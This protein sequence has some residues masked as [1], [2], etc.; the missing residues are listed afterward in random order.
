MSLFVKPHHLK[1]I[2]SGCTIV[3]L[4]LI[5]YTDDTSG[6]KSKEWTKFNVRCM[7]LAGLP[8]MVN[9]ITSTFYVAQTKW[10]CVI[11]WLMSLRNW[12]KKGAYDAALQEN[13]LIVAPVIYVS[14]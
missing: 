7:K 9:F 2:A 10:I 8:K 3:M 12:R 11:L 5:I 1:I 13:V 6:N 4:P 14:Q